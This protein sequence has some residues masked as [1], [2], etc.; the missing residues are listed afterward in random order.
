MAHS[1][2]E[3]GSARLVAVRAFLAEEHSARAADSW[4]SVSH[5]AS[6]VTTVAAVADYRGVASIASGAPRG[7]TVTTDA[8]GATTAE[9][10]GVASIA[11]GAPI[12]PTVTT[13]AT[14]ATV[15]YQPGYATVTAVGAALSC[16]AHTAG[17]AIAEQK[18]SV[19]AS[20]TV[21]RG[22]G[23][24]PGPTVAAITAERPA[25]APGSAGAGGGP[26]LSAVATGTAGPP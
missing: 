11:S 20:A 26:S 4:I 1:R 22:Y 10:P 14:G 8:T 17:T 23:G 5:S 6:A 3:R 2:H 15:A 19:A 24:A 18:A 12:E 16:T 13:G 25:V 21:S 9:Q 7:P